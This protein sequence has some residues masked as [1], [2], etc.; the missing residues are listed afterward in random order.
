[1][2]NTLFF[3]LALMTLN[4]QLHGL[5]HLKS[6]HPFI[7]GDCNL[8]HRGG[9]C[10]EGISKGSIWIVTRA[11][12]WPSALR[13]ERGSAGIKKSQPHKQLQYQIYNLNITEIF[14]NIVKIT[15]NLICQSSKLVIFIIWVIVSSICI[16]SSSQL[17]FLPFSIF[18]T[19]VVH[20]YYEQ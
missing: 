6:I 2:R 15:S 5:F 7:W 19:T 10:I 8:S 18:L 3:F 4:L 20:Q 13:L 9:H 17:I 1:M 16:S 14:K 12:Q 11:A